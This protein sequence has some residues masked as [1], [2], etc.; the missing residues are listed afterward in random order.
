M[1]RST[2]TPA[3][4]ASLLSPGCGGG[5]E[6]R[7]SRGRALQEQGQFDDSIAELGQVLERDPASGE[8]NY[9]LGLALVQTGDP[10]RAVWPLQK[11][12]EASGYEISA[13]VLLASTYFQTQNFD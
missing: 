10:S 7:M 11:A 13:G 6:S 5:I 1:F 12:A 3:A 2:K 4:L 8:A 9:R